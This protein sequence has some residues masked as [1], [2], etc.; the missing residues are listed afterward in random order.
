MVRVPLTPT[1]N[2]SPTRSAT[3]AMTNLPPALD[4]A[5]TFPGLGSIDDVRTEVDDAFTDARGF[6]ANE[7]DE[8]MRIVSGHSSRLSELRVQIMRIEDIHRQ[9]K[10]VRV[11]EIEP[12][13]DELREQYAIASRLHSVREL[14]WKMSGG[15]P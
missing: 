13:L 1:R 12:C 15:Q 5:R 14:D 10:T 6:H 3:A 2:G 8:V 4:T 11:R 7:P 9:W